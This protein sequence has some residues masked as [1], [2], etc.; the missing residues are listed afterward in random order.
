[1]A[2][3]LFLPCNVSQDQ[4]ST[5]RTAV[6][7]GVVRG[8]SPKLFFERHENEVLVRIENMN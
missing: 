6:V 3:G 7:V 1:M 4:L 2:A 5:I 8:H